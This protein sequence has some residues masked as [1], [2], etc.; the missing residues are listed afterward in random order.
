LFALLNLRPSDEDSD[1]WVRYSTLNHLHSNG[2]LTLGDL[3]QK[4]ES[5][6][7]RLNGVGRKF[8][9]EL[10]EIVHDLSSGRLKIGLEIEG[11][12]RP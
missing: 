3:I 12:K 1:Y 5:Q 2:L 4:S 8:L 10:K 9:N 11:W 6:L 7:L